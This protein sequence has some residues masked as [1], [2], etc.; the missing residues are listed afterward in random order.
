MYNIIMHIL[1]GHF[2]CTI[3]ACPVRILFNMDFTSKIKNKKGRNIWL[4]Y[5]NVLIFTM[6]NI[7][8]GL[9]SQLLLIESMFIL[10][11]WPEGHAST[12]HFKLRICCSVFINL[13]KIL[14]FVEIQNYVKLYK[15]IIKISI[16]FLLRK[17][18]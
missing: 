12:N 17:P 14:R 2:C 7:L 15:S 6:Q 11:I 4:F 9:L 8:L 18:N 1:H 10:S 5:W 3:W 16:I 13:I